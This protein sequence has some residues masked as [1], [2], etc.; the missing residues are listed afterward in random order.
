MNRYLDGFLRAFES[1]DFIILTY[2]ALGVFMAT[3]LLIL[4]MR[5]IK[6]YVNRRIGKIGTFSLTFED[7]EKMRQTGLI[8]ELEYSKIKSGIVRHLMEATGTDTPKEGVKSQDIPEIP[9]MP[10]TGAPPAR[11]SGPVDIDDLLKKGLISEEEYQAIYK[12]SR[13][14]PP[15]K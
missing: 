3:L 13:R 11:P 9:T 2:A 1:K 5:V 6:Y 14:N 12:I 8:T 7:I 10:P 15:K 4:A